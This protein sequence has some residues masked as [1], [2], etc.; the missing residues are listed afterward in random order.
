MVH[1]LII[2]IIIIVGMMFA[3]IVGP[4]VCACLVAE[5]MNILGGKEYNKPMADAK[6][7]MRIREQVLKL[8]IPDKR[9]DLSFADT[10]K[11][12][13]EGIRDKSPFSM[14]LRPENK[15]LPYRRRPFDVKP[16]IHWGQLKL[17]LSELRFIS[18]H[19][20]FSDT[21]VYAGASPGTHIKY[22]SEMFPKHKF[23]LWDP[24]KFN[25]KG[26][27]IETHEE[28]FTD[29]V[30]QQ[31]A[32]KNILFISD[33]RTGDSKN[34]SDEFEG[35][36]AID[37][38]WQ[39]NWHKIIKPSMGMYK[40]RLPYA[41]GKIEYMAGTLQMQVFAP[42]STTELRLIVPQEMKMVV[43]D[44]VQVEEQMY[45]F[46]YFTRPKWFGQP[47]R[48][49]HLDGC[50]DCTA[51]I[52][53]VRRYMSTVSKFKS[54]SADVE[55]KIVLQHVKNILAT[56]SAINKLNS[57]PHGDG[58]NKGWF[59]RWRKYDNMVPSQLSKQHLG[60]TDGMYDMHLQLIKEAKV[61]YPNLLVP[62]MLDYD[63][64]LKQ[65]AMKKKHN[66][67]NNK[68]KNYTPN[69]KQM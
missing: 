27:M 58:S 5:N 56:C 16:V 1:F 54:P 59:E 49:F 43:Y 41:D 7:E 8:V 20:H 26:P 44:N 33:I 53:I 3:C 69:N 36:V 37:M 17:F 62:P 35:R 57:P 31:Y 21:I 30:A 65:H 48:D 34:E 47:Y 4:I 2:I 15:R 61:K 6:D 13:E 39:M 55:K 64:A 66:N 19:G 23:I 29:E 51:F 24:R 38:E 14:I 25:V 22:L 12:E 9:P 52:T 63:T 42:T 46:N 18:E 10:L 67:A 32:N 45:F 40:F 28:Y 50:W 11:A 68:K 60:I